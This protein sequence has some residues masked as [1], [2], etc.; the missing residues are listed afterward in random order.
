MRRDPEARAEMLHRRG[1]RRI[2][3]E[4]RYA[5]L[6]TLDQELSASIARGIV[7]TAL[8][9]PI[10]LVPLNDVHLDILF[11]FIERNEL[12]LAL[13]TTLMHPHDI[14]EWVESK[15][16]DLTCEAVSRLADRASKLGCSVALYN[17]DGWF[18]QPSSLCKIVATARRPNVGIVYNFHHAHADAPEFRSHVVSMLSSLKAV[19]LG[20]AKA[21]APAA[22]G[23]GEHDFAM[24]STLLEMGYCGPLGLTCYDAKADA[25]DTLT[26]SLAGL[27][28]FRRSLEKRQTPS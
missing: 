19:N 23:E 1:L 17:H 8:W 22:F 4:W 14:D 7:A 25:A 26:R 12:R 11:G 20:A 10:S 6:G 16:L 21:G 13:W 15:K 27:A 3:I 18:A 5:Q 24:L 28:N 9:V 2:A